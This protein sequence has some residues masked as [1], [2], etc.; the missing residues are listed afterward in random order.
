[1][2]AESRGAGWWI[3]ALAGIAIAAAAFAFALPR[4]ASYDQVWAVLGDLDRRWLPVVAILGA[5][6]LVAPSL[7]FRAALAGLRLRHALVM[8]WGTTAVTNVVPGGSAF[9]IGLTWSMLRSFGF[10]SSAIT[11]AIVVTGVWDVFVKLGTPLLA[12]AWL[13]IVQPVSAGLLQAAAFGA[14]LFVI[15]VVFG[16]VVLTGGGSSGG[17]A[18]SVG[19]FV[20]RLRIAGDGWPDRLEEARRETAVLL[21]DRWRRLTWWTAFGHA[22]LY[23]LLVVCLRA[24]GIGGNQLGLAQVLAAFAFGRLITAVPLTPGG[25]GVL[26]VGLVGA[27]GAVGAAPEAGIVAAVL[28]FRFLNLVVPLPLGALSLL[29]WRLGS[30]SSREPQAERSDGTST[31]GP[32][33]S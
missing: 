27:L 32:A 22:N 19:R 8:D 3:R 30:V 9:A 1:M 2:S 20:D 5:T 24:V 21:S 6:N 4:F 17:A 26:E 23:L 7:S 31:L 13:A 28:V 25:L 18:G 14:V 15:A 12:V 16:Q 10:A 33:Q 11:R 29:W